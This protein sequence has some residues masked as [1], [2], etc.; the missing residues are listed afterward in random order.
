MLKKFTLLAVAASAAFSVF[1]QKPDWEKVETVY[2][3]L[4][5]K[6]A[7]PM[8]KKYT[9]DIIMDSDGLEA[10]K[11][12]DREALI[13]SITTTNA[14][15][16]KQGKATQPY[17]KEEEIYYNVV[18]DPNS[19]KG[20]LKLDGCQIVSAAPEFSVKVKVSGFDIIGTALL[21]TERSKAVAATAT[22]AAVP[23]TYNYGYDVKYTYKFGYELSDASGTVV[24]EELIAGTDVALSKKTK[25]FTSIQALEAWWLS[26]DCKTTFK[27]VCDNE[28]Y[29]NSLSLTQ[30][31]LNSELGYVV[32]T[33]KLNV[34]T[35][36]DA[37][38]Y[39]DIVAA[40][41][42][43]S[44]GY[45]YL[46]ADKKKADD[47][48]LK[49]VAAWE[50]A[51]K[52]YDPAAKKQRISDDVAGAL[53][54]N[55]AIAY[56][57]LEDWPQCNHNLVKLKAMDKGGKLKNRLEDADAFKADYEARVKANKVN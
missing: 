6:P 14:I 41:S 45:N 32:K 43:A 57:L 22:T 42:D 49:S 1:A 18:R 23:A 15:L 53:Y 35:M 48:I 27:S 10:N 47:Y 36:K 5:S 26:L 46:S 11:A 55:L 4:P 16:A 8:A 7:S 21:T 50:K 33:V 52:E 39:A 51:V 24:R 3:Q 25:T 19:I 40:F 31:Q 29:R 9:M 13:Q 20:A 28:A 34:A 17:P 12:S 44:M 2:T 54:A 38:V 30:K 37:A 56:C